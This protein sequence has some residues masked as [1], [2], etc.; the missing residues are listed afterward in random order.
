MSPNQ[1]RRAGLALTA[2]FCSMGFCVAVFADST[3][4]AYNGIH[5][6]TR[7]DVSPP[8]KDIPPLRVPST[9]QNKGGLMVDP[10]GFKDPPVYGPQEIAPVVQG[11]KGPVII[12]APTVSFNG[13]P[14]LS[15]VS[16]P[17]P[18]GDIG[19]DHYVVMSNLF[20]EVYDRVG[21]SVFGPAAN[22][23]LWSGFGGACEAQNAG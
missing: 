4:G 23:T 18:V 10:S 20:F 7:F 3:R 16:P 21:N 8:L 17:D 5:T 19:P 22:N 15:G 6:V 9:G 1:F 11:S 2:M 14:N 12:P 13:P